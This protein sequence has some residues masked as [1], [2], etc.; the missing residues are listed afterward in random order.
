[1]VKIIL[2]VFICNRSCV[3]SEPPQINVSLECE[4]LKEDIQEWG[5]VT[6]EDGF[7]C[8][9]TEKAVPSVSSFKVTEEAPALESQ[10]VLSSTMCAN[11]ENQIVPKRITAVCEVCSI[12][13][14]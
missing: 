7:Q 1:M 14:S 3:I 6:T 11:K 8:C 12:S 2:N 13:N 5:N 10:N 9:M 4:Q